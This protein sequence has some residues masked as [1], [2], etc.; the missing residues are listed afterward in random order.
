VTIAKR[1]SLIERGTREGDTDFGKSESG[2]FFVAGLDGWNRVER[3]WEIRFL[4]R[5]I[6]LR[7]FVRSRAGPIKIEV[8]CPSG[9]R[10]MSTP[11]GDAR[12][13][14]MAGRRPGHPR[15]STNEV[16]AQAFG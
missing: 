15:L 6:F 11:R 2:I 16:T 5:A 12:S 10:L 7:G 3:A 14:F 9:Q 8:I 4:A 1:P 13:A